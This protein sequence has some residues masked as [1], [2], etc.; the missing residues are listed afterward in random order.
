M[1]DD[2]ILYENLRILIYEVKFV[3]E[4]YIENCL[5]NYVILNFICILDDEM[6]DNCV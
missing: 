5:N 2:F 4:M 1:K 6:K 3:K